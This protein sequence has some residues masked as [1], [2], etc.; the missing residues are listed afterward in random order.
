M[1]RDDEPKTNEWVT[2]SPLRQH[3][4][5][6]MLSPP[7]AALGEFADSLSRRWSAEKSFTS[8]GNAG[9]SF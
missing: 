5:A 1:E 8:K 4:A 7:L 3:K 2:P 6:A 9:P